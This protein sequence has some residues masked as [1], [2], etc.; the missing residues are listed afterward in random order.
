MIYMTGDV[1]VGAYDPSRLSNL[2]IGHGAVNGGLRLHLSQSQD[3][4][5]VLRQCSALR[6]TSPII[7]P[8][9]Q[10]GVDMLFDWGAS[11]F[12]TEQFLVGSVG[13]AYDEVGCNSGSGDRVGCF[14]SPRIRRRAAGR[15]Q[16]LIGN[17][18]NA[19]RPDGWNAWVTFVLSPAQETPSAASR[20]MRSM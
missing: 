3:R 5:G 14:Q 1:P 8:Q 16:R 13:Y 2:G 11:Q 18:D 19:N 20:R 9:Y 17:F 10:N 15:H 4:P 12:L 6:T 7:R